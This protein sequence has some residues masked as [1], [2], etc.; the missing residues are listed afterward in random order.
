MRIL[1]IAYARATE[2]AYEAQ[3]LAV[4]GSSLV[5]TATSTADQVRAFLFG[6]SAIVN[7]TTGMPAT[8]DLVA[9]AE[10]LR[11]GGLTG[12]YPAPY[13]TNNVPGTADAASLQVNVSGLPIVRAPF[14]TGNVHLVLN[15][16]SAR[17]HEDGPFPIS[18]EDVSK[19]GQNVAIWGLGTGAT[20]VP[21]GIVKSTLT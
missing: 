15:A 11:L 12:L 8:V 7:D 1:A 19:L 13:G 20:T 9:P 16:E 14:L 5:L 2:A 6:A 21:K 17:W 4:A 10:W 3:L 18:A